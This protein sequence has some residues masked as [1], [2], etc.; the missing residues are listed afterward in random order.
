[1]GRDLRLA[2]AAATLDRTAPLTP[3]VAAQ[4][5]QNVNLPVIVI[6]KKQL[7]GED[8]ASDQAPVIS[9]LSQVNAKRIKPYR[10]INA[11]AATASDG[12]VARLKVNPSVAKV[13]PDVVIHRKSHAAAAAS[14]AAENGR[15]L[16]SVIAQ[17]RRQ[18]WQGLHSRSRD[19]W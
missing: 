3:E 15:I 17:L 6:M 16:S 14:T 9:E 13:I 8:A 10:M 18:P 19:K 5:S 12:E 1:V 4:L 11:F 2:Y 7:A